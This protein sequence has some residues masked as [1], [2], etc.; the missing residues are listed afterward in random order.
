MVYPRH[1]TIHNAP[2]SRIAQPRIK[3][4]EQLHH[5]LGPTLLVG[6]QSAVGQPTMRCN[7][8]ICL[9]IEGQ[10][11]HQRLLMEYKKGEIGEPLAMVVH[12]IAQEKESSVT[13]FANETV[14]LGFQF[15]RISYYFVHS[16]LGVVG[17][18]S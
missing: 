6:Y 8:P 2:Y 17:V 4:F 14:P 10:K 12:I 1:G 11:S 18:K 5:L 3:A 16:E 9:F 13:T 15:R 7:T